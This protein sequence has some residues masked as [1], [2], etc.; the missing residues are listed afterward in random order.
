M[1]SDN[2]P[3]STRN[4]LGCILVVEDDPVLALSIEA[5]LLDAGAQ[6]V[7]VCAST[8][9]TLE[10]LGES[11]PDGVVLDIHLSDRDD[12]WALAELLDQLGPPRPRIV[13]STGS[14]EEIPPRIAEMGPVFEK[15]YDPAQL[16]EALAGEDRRG[17]FARLRAA[18]G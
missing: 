15:P 14:P 3:Q 7:V 11:R 2:P 4:R 16:V 18:M 8:A 1:T 13:F 17:F 5:A 9:R 12:G 10:A 6:Q